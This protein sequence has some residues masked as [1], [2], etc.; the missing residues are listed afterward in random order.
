MLVVL[1]V[2]VQ[3]AL[4]TPPRTHG[5]QRPGAGRPRLHPAGLVRVTVYLL[6]EQLSALVRLG[7]GDVSAAVRQ[8]LDDSGIV[9]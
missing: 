6:P 1:G 3:D 4:P 8:V 2:P 7:D 5:G 9:T